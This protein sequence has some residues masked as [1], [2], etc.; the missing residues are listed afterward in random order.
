MVIL[1]I[2]HKKYQVPLLEDAQAVMD[3]LSTS[4][5][6]EYAHE[7]DAFKTSENQKDGIEITITNKPLLKKDDE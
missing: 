1:E 6:V 7:Q 5:I 2:G 3:I 4:T